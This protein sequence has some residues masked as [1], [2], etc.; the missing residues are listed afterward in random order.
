VTLIVGVA[1]LL[2][3]LSLSGFSAALAQASTSKARAQLAADAAALAAVA[4]S[5]PHGAGEHESVAA[6]FAAANG[7]RVIECLCEPGATAVEVKVAV[8]D[9]VASARAIFDASKL[10]PVGNV[11]TTGLHPALRSAVDRL[12][13]A[14]RG[15]VVLVSGFRS[16]EEQTRLW[17]DALSRYGDPEVADDWV[18]R[19]GSSMHER[20]LAVDLG[21]DLGSA[22]RLVEILGLP[23]FQP[24]PHELHHFELRV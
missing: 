17:N 15:E 8:G 12:L 16:G 2:L 21:G 10:M 11:T 1:A 3:A 4:E 22:S 13:A 9:V 14:A 19:P 5:S 24:M 18:A 20:G 23:L 7:A 6:R